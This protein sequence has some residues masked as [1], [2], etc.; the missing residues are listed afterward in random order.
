MLCYTCG[1]CISYLVIIGD[2][3]LLVFKFF[4]P[5]IALLQS[6]AFVVGVICVCFVFPLCLM[7]SKFVYSV[8]IIA[9]D[10][11]RYVSVLSILSIFVTVGVVFWEFVS[12]PV[13]NPTVEVWHVTARYLLAVPIMCVSF[14]C[15]YNVPRYYYVW[16]F[17]IH[18]HRN[19]RIVLLV[20]CGWL[21]LVLLV[22]FSLCIL[23]CLVSIFSIFLYSVWL[24]E[25]WYLHKR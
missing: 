16:S 22:S 23:W 14:N 6:R 25:V 8:L 15:H 18:Y 19:W 4:C 11:L 3:F 12:A 21:A 2:L 1:S 5:T 17:S 10:A 13:V 20:V 24:L 9:V 7:K